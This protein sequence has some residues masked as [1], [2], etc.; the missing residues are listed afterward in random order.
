M[1]LKRFLDDLIND[2]VIA[3]RMLLLAGPRQVGKTT[4][5]KEWLA[6]SHYENLYYN[7]DFE[8]TRRQFR[9]DANFF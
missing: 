7:W 5:A 6:S 1:I 4:T 8:D 3:D 9:H 2:P